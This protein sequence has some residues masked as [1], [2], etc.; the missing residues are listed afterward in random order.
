M[1]TPDIDRR[2]IIE[3]GIQACVALIRQ[4]LGKSVPM[5]MSNTG[6]LWCNI[7]IE[8]KSTKNRK[9]RRGEGEIPQTKPQNQNKKNHGG[10]KFNREIVEALKNIYK[11]ILSTVGSLFI[12]MER[13]VV[14]VQSIQLDDQPALSLASAA[15][16]T[17]TIDPHKASNI[18]CTHTIQASSLSLVF[19]IFQRYSKHR[20]IILEDLFPLMLKIPKAKKMMRIFPIRSS[21]MIHPSYSKN[22]NGPCKDGMIQPLSALILCLIQGCVSMPVLLEDGDINKVH[23]SNKKGKKILKLSNGLSDSIQVCN[24][25][26][27]QLL[28]RCSRKGVSFCSFVHNLDNNVK[29][30]YSFP[31]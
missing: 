28:R 21:M 4:H 22:I 30:Q 27:V 16:S 29:S 14:L 15:M 19:S 11:P 6:H 5:A 3:D 17:F 13:I 9:R 7:D 25:F 1:N 2:L 31:F 18:S 12:L 26:I 8:K 20:A 24:F 10:M 23:K